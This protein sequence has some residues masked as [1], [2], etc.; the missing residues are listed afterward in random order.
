MGRH[1]GRILNRHFGGDW[2]AF[3]QSIRDNFD[4]TQLEDFGQVMHDNIYTWYNNAEEA[5]LWRPALEHITFLKEDTTMPENSANP[6]AGKTVVATG[7]LQN[8]NREGIQMKLL[9][10][11]AKPASSVSK[12]T[13]YLIVGENAG[14]KLDKARSLGV[15]TITEEEFEHLLVN[16]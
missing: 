11:G 12:K 9:S 16:S 3:E 5:K 6:F 13:D 8:Y 7:K 15:Q 14:S 1:A 2:E 4:F 10:L